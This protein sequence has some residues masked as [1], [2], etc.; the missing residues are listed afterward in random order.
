MVQ[1]HLSRLAVPTA[2]PVSRKKTKWITRMMPGPHHSE[3]AIPLSVLLRDVLGYARTMKEIK[4]IL[5]NNGVLLDKRARREYKYP[6]GLMDV[7]EL[8]DLEEFYRVLYDRRGFI[9]VKKISA[10][11]SN[12][13][14]LKIV[15]KSAVKN[16]MIQ[17][18]FHDGRN[19]KLEKPN[20]DV[21][22]SVLFDVSKKSI[23]K[24][25]PLDSGSLVYLSGGTHIGGFGTV[26]EIIKAKNLQKP[27]VVVAIGGVEY[28]TPV[29]YVFVVGKG[30]SEL[31][32]GVSNE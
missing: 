4:L 22:D 3:G 20:A 25:I 21:G 29:E 16:G 8:P 14:I 19:I 17:L 11:E 24:F 13:K 30:K 31:D 6:V 18:T 27:K 1:N 15:R 2:W 5:N 7:V 9:I 26:K 32:L 10:K 12:L 23:I 28:T